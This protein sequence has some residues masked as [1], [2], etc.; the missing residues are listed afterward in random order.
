MQVST[1]VVFAP[2]GNGTW[3]QWAFYDVALDA[4]GRRLFFSASGRGTSEQAPEERGG[5]G[6]AVKARV[7]M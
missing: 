4:L 2:V 7:I 1:L 6:G 5:G 3:Q